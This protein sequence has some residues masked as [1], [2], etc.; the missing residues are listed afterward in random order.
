MAKL[1]TVLAAEAGTWHSGGCYSVIFLG[2]GEG[3]PAQGVS[4]G[5]ECIRASGGR[6]VRALVIDVR[7]TPSRGM[8]TCMHAFP[9]AWRLAGAPAG[10]PRCILGWTVNPSMV[11]IR[12]SG[13]ALMRR[14]L[15]TRKQ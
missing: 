14:P 11:L 4:L 10:A 3:R 9:A 15:P 1:A 7:D 2:G 5:A 8:G 13:H 12:A 6:E